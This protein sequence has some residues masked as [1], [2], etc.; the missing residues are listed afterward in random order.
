VVIVL[1]GAASTNLAGDLSESLDE[2][3][4]NP[5]D[6]GEN[7]P[8]GNSWKDASLALGDAVLALPGGLFFQFLIHFMAYAASLLNRF[9]HGKDKTGNGLVGEMG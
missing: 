3:L 7:L 8:D 6:S 4:G 2:A 1:D 5:T 9:L